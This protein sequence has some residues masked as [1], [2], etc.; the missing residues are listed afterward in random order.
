MNVAKSEL[1]FSTPILAKIAVNAANIAE[2][3]AQTCQLAVID[4]STG[5]GDWLCFSPG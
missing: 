4:F 2:S 3:K 5:V 1:M